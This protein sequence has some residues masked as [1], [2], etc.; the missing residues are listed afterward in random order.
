MATM[1]NLGTP[2]NAISDPTFESNISALLRLDKN[3]SQPEK[4]IRIG[5]PRMAQSGNCSPRTDLLNQSSVATPMRKRLTFEK[6]ASE[7]MAD[8]ELKIAKGNTQLKES[9]RL[10]NFDHNKT[11]TVKINPDISNSQK[12]DSKINEAK[13]NSFL[14]SPKT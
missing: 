1:L 12:F 2:F 10:V 4:T 3:N 9:R 7:N 8:I 11:M 6:K 14:K 5:R 13:S